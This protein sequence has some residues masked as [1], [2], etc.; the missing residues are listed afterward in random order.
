MDFQ[1][2]SHF[3]NERAKSG[4]GHGEGNFLPAS[5]R[6]PPPPPRPSEN[7]LYL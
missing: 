3:F 1:C 6:P 7:Y 2:S 5:V 4:R